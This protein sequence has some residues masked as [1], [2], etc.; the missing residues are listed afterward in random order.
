MLTQWQDE[1]FFKEVMVEEGVL[2]DEER[3]MS[4]SLFPYTDDIPWSMDW[5]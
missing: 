3:S 1:V 5:V 2:S 4:A